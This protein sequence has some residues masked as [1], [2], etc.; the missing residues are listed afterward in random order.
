MFDTNNLTITLD[1]YIILIL[2]LLYTI[3]IRTYILSGMSKYYY[4]CKDCNFNTDSIQEADEHAFL[5]KHNVIHNCFGRNK[6]SK[7]R[8]CKGEI[9]KYKDIIKPYTPPNE[10]KEEYIKWVIGN[11]Q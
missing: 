10:K 7:Y 4:S 2:I 8:N 9:I 5:K 11:S 6:N 1:I 3:I